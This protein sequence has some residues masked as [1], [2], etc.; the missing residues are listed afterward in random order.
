MDWDVFRPKFCFDLETRIIRIQPLSSERDFL[1]VVIPC[2]FDQIPAQIMIWGIMRK[3]TVKS[4]VLIINRFS[5]WV[6][7]CQRS[8]GAKS[9]FY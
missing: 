7:K 5:D 1:V 3:I 6:Q 8:A 2:P 4:K 9:I